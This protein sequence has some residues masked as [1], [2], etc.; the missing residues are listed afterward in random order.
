MAYRGLVSLAV[1]GL[2][3]SVARAETAGIVFAGVSVACML[4]ARLAYGANYA[5]AA[6]SFRARRIKSLEFYEA[7][8]RVL[9]R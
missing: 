2:V 1:V 4:I 8:G 7:R 6:A 5:L 3:A 9:K